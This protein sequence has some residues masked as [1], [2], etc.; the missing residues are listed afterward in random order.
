MDIAKCSPKLSFDNI[1]HYNME[2]KSKENKTDDII[3]QIYNLSLCDIIIN[4]G[5]SKILYNNH[6]KYFNPKRNQEVNDML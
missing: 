4:G 5:N 2:F 3:E 6:F 1:S